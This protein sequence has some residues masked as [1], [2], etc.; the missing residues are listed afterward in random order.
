MTSFLGFFSR[1]EGDLASFSYF[2]NLLFNKVKL[3]DMA[4]DPLRE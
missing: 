3:N 2:D 4:A 1:F